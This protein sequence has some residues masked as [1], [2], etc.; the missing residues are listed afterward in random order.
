[1]SGEVQLFIVGVIV[2]AAL[3]YVMRS[4]WKLMTNRGK[5]GCGSGC[6]KCATTEPIPES[7][8]ISLPQV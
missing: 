4:A 5:P 8:R 3:A 7:G 2:L 6:G 1:M